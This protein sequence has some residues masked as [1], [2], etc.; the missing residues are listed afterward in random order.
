MLLLALLSWF[1]W[2]MVNA[3]FNLYDTDEN[4][5]INHLRVN[6]LYFHQIYDGDTTEKIDYCLNPIENNNLLTNVFLNTRAQHFT[7]DQL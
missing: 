4:F 7:Y 1:L 5:D 6:C 2:M 3:Q